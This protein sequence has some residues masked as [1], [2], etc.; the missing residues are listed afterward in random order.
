MKPLKPYI[1]LSKIKEGDDS[2]VGFEL[3]YSVELNRAGVQYYI[4]S[5]TTES[6]PL[7]KAERIVQ[8][9]VTATKPLDPLSS[10]DSISLYIVQNKI[11]APEKK[12]RVLV[13]SSD[14]GG[15]EEGQ[16]TIHYDDAD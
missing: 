13:N 16:S 10:D 5:R 7:D 4:E 1:H 11:F 12:I 14:G 3:S 6:G 2:L 9:N 8:L 15:D